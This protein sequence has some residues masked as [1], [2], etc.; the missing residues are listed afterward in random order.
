MYK[1]IP[2]VKLKTKM[3]E[4]QGKQR[5]LICTALRG[6][7]PEAVKQGKLRKE[8]ECTLKEKGVK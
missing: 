4:L 5:A 6:K 8:K 1:A 3:G 7:V 2:A